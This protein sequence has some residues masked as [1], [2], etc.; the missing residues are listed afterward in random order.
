MNIF[1]QTNNKHSSNRI[2]MLDGERLLNIHEQFF[3]RGENLFKIGSL[4]KL[5][6]GE[7][8][9]T[10]VTISCHFLCILEMAF[11]HWIYSFNKCLNAYYMPGT[12][13]STGDTALT[14]K[15]PCPFIMHTYW[16]SR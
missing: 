6:K 7:S 3:L 5:K 11:C 4:K 10:D 2:Y 8:S 14:E 13:L 16:E 1:Y 15:V 12:V 9:S